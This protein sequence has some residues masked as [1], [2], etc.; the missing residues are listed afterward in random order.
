MKQ[1]DIKSV[2]LEERSFPPSKEFAARARLKL[3]DA[4]RGK[5][6]SA[7]KKSVLKKSMLKRRA[8]K[9]RSVRK[10]AARRRARRQPARKR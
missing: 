1:K 2:L 3:A 4:S 6:K 8:P 7:T 9:K 5:R 10:P